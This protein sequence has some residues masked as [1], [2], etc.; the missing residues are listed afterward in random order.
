[1][2]LIEAAAAGRPAVAS[3]VGGVPEVVTGETGFV[4]PPGDA[5]GAGRG[6]IAAWHRIRVLRAE[7][8]ANARR[9]ALERHSIPRLLADVDALY[10][11][12]LEG[13]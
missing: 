5:A 7:L 9:R 6:G 13:R 10:T 2:S 11:E 12:L 3:R 4:F 1:M 8:G